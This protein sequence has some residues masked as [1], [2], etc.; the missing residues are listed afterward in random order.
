METYLWAIGFAVIGSVF[1]S[2]G[3]L[4][5][6]RAADETENFW[7]LIM[8]RK[9]MI[10]GFFYGVSFILGLAAYR[11]GDLSIIYPVFALSYVWTSFLSIKYLEEDMN[12]WKWTGVVCILLGVFLL[13]FGV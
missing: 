6:K 1:S 8:T 12:S 9:Y 5:L 2:I 7:R 13:G 11:G 4:F 3:S 10:G